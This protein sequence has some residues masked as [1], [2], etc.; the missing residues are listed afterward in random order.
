[1]SVIIDFKEF[2]FFSVEI[3]IKENKL[4]CYYLFNN[5]ILGICE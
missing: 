4:I 3:S 1:M 2:I 5:I